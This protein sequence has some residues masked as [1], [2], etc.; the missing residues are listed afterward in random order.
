MSKSELEL[1][2]LGLWQWLAPELPGPQREYR[3]APPRRFRFDFAWPE[4]R[5]A[6][7]VE[8]GTWAGG[9]HVRPQGYGRDCEKYNL[10]VALGWRV[11]RFT[12]GMLDSDPQG[13]IAQVRE[14]VMDSRQFKGVAWLVCDGGEEE[15]RQRFRARF[16]EEPARVI[17]RDGW[18]WAGPCPEDEDNDRGSK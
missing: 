11:F 5:V 15:A 7:E 10:A 8:G 18:W 6:V 2:F 3:F 4:H 16:G 9:R 17:R 12:G 1:A 14:A 13:C